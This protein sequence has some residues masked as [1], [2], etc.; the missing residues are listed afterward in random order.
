MRDFLQLGALVDIAEQCSLPEAL[1]SCFHV[2]T[3]TRFLSFHSERTLP[4]TS[5]LLGLDGSPPGGGG[6]GGGGP[7]NG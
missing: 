4:L 2:V 6:G 3:E 5:L 1:T 7:A